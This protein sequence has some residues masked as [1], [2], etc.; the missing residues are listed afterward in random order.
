MS[1]YKIAAHGRMEVCFLNLMSSSSSPKRV[2][3]YTNRLKSFTKGSYH[4]RLYSVFGEDFLDYRRRWEAAISA[5]SV[6]ECEGPIHVDLEL[7]NSCNYRCSFCPYSVAK[8][9]RPKGFNSEGSMETMPFELVEKVLSQSYSL[10]ARA[11]ELGYNTEPLLYPRLFDVIALARSLGYLDIRMGTNG[12]LLTSKVS[13]NLIQAG[14][15]QLQVSVDAVDERSYKK[16]RNSSLYN[17]VVQNIN[18]FLKLRSDESSSL[19]LL[20]LTYVMTPENAINSSQF[21]EQWSQKAD[22]VT[23]QELFTYENVNKSSTS[24]T[25]ENSD[26]SD[27]MDSNCY[28]P[29]VRLS[30]KSDGS[31]HPCCTVPG[32]SLKVGDLNHMSVSD[33]WSSPS[34]TRIRKSHIEGTWGSNQTCTDCMT[35]IG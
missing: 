30:V 33:V 24:S 19:P 28:M 13:Q 4:S 29:K 11:L 25:A 27:S 20:R 5:T 21:L 9:F 2:E 14:L 1:L 32:M 15:T 35:N 34:F 26:H 7:S 23:L 6:D 18:S 10:G 12:S 31:V 8:E 16:S 3:S 17:K 22:Q